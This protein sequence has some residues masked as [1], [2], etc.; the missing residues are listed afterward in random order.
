VRRGVFLLFVFLAACNPSNTQDACYAFAHAE[1]QRL[2]DLSSH[3]CEGAT[4]V[5]SQRGLSSASQCESSFTLL[6]WTCAQISTNQCAATNA[7]G[8]DYSSDRA[9]ACASELGNLA[10]GADFTLDSTADCPHICCLPSESAIEGD[11]AQ[12]C[13]GQTHQIEITGCGPNPIPETVCN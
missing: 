5:I 6:G 12:C 13:S 7:P 10:C 4:N 2:F 11:A 1:C 8:P 9:G 3:G